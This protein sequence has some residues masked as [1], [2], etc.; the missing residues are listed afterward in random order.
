MELQVSFHEEIQYSRTRL[1]IRLVAY[2]VCGGDF[3]QNGGRWK[4][5]P[6]F[7]DSGNQCTYT[8]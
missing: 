7:R 3:L 6:H 4:S 1:S 8:S 5:Q 2:V